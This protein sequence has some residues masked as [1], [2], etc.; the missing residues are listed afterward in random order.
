MTAVLHNCGRNTVQWPQ[1]CRTVVV[2]PPNDRS[3]TQLWSQNCAMTAMLPNCGRSAVPIK[4]LNSSL[5]T[6]FFL[7]GLKCLD[8]LAEL[9]FI[10][11]G[12]DSPPP[13]SEL[14]DSVDF[15]LSLKYTLIKGTVYILSLK[16]TNNW[17]CFKSKWFEWR[18]L[19]CHSFDCYN[20]SIWIFFTLHCYFKLLLLF[21]IT[22]KN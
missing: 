14:L 16:S 21:S 12:L 22:L 5:Y 19:E 9:F 7:R 3:A 20:F 13:S 15:L 11:K 10:F 2:T 1:C 8:L 4:A 17:N 18:K 6:F